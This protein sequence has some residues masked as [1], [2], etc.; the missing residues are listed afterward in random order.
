MSKQIHYSDEPLEMRRAA[1]FL[2]SPE[3]LALKGRRTKVT[4]SLSF[5]SVDYFKEMAKKHHIQYQKMIRELPDEYVARRKA[6]DKP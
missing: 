3:E 4:N 1:D 2:P 5:E 6:A